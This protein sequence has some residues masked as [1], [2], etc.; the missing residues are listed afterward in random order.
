[1]RRHDE[2]SFSSGANGSFNETQEALDHENLA[3]T[4]VYVQRI[5]VKVDKHSRKI[6]ERLK[7]KK[8]GGTQN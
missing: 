7:R 3:M 2:L 8:E 1:M 4:R 6:A 5:A